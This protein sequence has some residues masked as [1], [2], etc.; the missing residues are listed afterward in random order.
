MRKNYD[1]RWW[2]KYP[3]GI[4]FNENGMANTVGANTVKELIQHVAK[5]RNL[6]NFAIFKQSSN[7][8]STTLLISNL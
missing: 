1:W 4:Y 6:D 5:A 8:H 7:F 2:K 3:Y